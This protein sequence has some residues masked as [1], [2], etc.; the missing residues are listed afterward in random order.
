MSQTVREAGTAATS[1]E[2]RTSR[3][4]RARLCVMMFLQYFVEGCY[5]PIISVYLQD[6]FGFDASQL[7]YVGAAL[8]MGTVVAP[9]ILGQLVDRHVDT[10]NVLCVC[11]LLSG[12][13]MLLLYFQTSVTAVVVLGTVYSSVYVPSRMLANSM[14]FHHL[15]SRDREFPLIRLW[16]TIGFIVPA[17]LIELW[18]L[19]GLEG[20]DLNKARGI[21]LAMAGV[22]GLVLGLYS[23]TMPK[24]PPPEREAGGFAPGKVLALMGHRRFL[25]LVLVSFGIAIAHQFYFVWNSPFI[26]AVLQAGGEVGAWE[27]RVS[28]LGQIAEIGVLGAVGLVILR[29]GFKRVMTLG[30]FCYLLRCFILAGAAALEEPFGLVMTLV[31]AGQVLHGFCFGCFLA[32][33]FMYV[34]RFAPR[35]I[36]GSMQNVYGTLIVGTGFFFGSLFGGWVGAMYTTDV[37]NAT[38]RDQLGIALRS[39]MMAFTSVERNQE[40]I[41]DWPGI[42]LTCAA[43][44]AVCWV[45]FAVFFPRRRA[46]EAMEAEIPGGGSR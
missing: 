3:S 44:V 15:A 5:L 29:V 10:Q 39:G 36:R 4:V 40:Q 16:G 18:W 20:Q 35:D 2:A 17:W 38:V 11:H 8:A 42:W 30:I 45:V 19:S 7:G 26:R 34:D 21:A 46:E 22:G 37:G 23:L 6:A 32:V 28:S 24:T 33:A 25:V 13:V 9:F 41:R 27:Q 43:L 1:P 14:A 12:A 31:C